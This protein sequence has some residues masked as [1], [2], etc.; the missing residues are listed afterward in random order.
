MSEDDDPQ[1]LNGVA[2]WEG[3][4]NSAPVWKRNADFLVTTGTKPGYKA[5]YSNAITMLRRDGEKWGFWYNTFS[6]RHM[7]NARPINDSDI[8]AVCDWYH[9]GGCECSIA[10]AQA[11]LFRVAE[12][13]SRNPVLEYL[14]ALQWDGIARIDMMLIDHAGV[15]DTPLM[16]AQTKG[17]MI[18]AVARAFEPGCQADATIILEG[19]QAIG[20]STLLRELFGDEY[21]TDH[22]P[23]LNTGKE[24][25]LQLRGIWCLEIAE[26]ASFGKSEAAKIKQF[27]TSRIDRYRDP[28]GLTTNDWPRTCVF[29]GTV[30]PGSEAYL[31]DETG[32]RRFWPIRCGEVDIQSIRDNRDRYWAEA[33]HRYKAAE[34]WHLTD[35]TLRQAAEVQQSDRG[36]SDD[37]EDLIWDYCN[38][39]TPLLWVTTREII[40]GPLEKSQAKDWDRGDQMRVG[41]ILTRQGWR[42]SV[43]RQ[44]SNIQRG[45]VRKN[46]E[47]VTETGEQLPL[48]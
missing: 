35:Y 46:L 20:K 25:M 26:M 42:K 44:G 36:E 9:H 34:A 41:K 13:V 30:N 32:A 11:A 22:L 5:T 45:Y 27:L 14:N 40:A 1:H 18:Q 28:Y 33:V 21:F 31:K 4:A 17:F 43:K 16:R 47:V 23:E 48:I 7:R 12:M 15:E 39:G 29:A 24:A 37:W 10:V 8:R 38:K 2:V 19:E 3:T 6:F